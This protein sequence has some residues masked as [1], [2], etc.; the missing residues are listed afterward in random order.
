MEHKTLYNIENVKFEEDSVTKDNNDENTLNLELK[1]FNGP[2]DLLV[3][4][5]QSRKL[6]ITKI[7]ILALVDQYLDFIKKIKKKNLNLASD[8]LVMAAVL[9]Y[10]KLPFGSRN[11]VLP[12]VSS[13]IAL[14]LANFLILFL[15]K[16]V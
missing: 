14:P 13:N 4:L 2:L 8:Y 11:T 12:T 1:G 16:L 3:S 10:I 5:A 9:A 7:S 15:E 6:D